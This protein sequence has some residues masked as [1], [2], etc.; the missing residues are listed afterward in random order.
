MDLVTQCEE[1]A[2]LSIAQLSL[3]RKRKD[4]IPFPIPAL[5]IEDHETVL[6]VGLGCC[7]RSEQNKY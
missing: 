1:V 2:V 6:Q 7:C 5:Q 4:L 3:G